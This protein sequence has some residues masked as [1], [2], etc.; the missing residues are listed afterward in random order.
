MPQNRFFLVRLSAMNGGT[1]DARIPNITLEDDK[2]QKYEELSDGEGAPQWIGF[3]RSARPS[4]S[5]QGN[6][7]FDVPP[8]HYK[9]TVFDEDRSHTA[10]IDIPLSFG[11]ETPEIVSPGDPRKQ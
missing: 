4:D 7:L 1:S 9:A 8:G 10:T 5:V 2:G 3:L 11:A 6:I